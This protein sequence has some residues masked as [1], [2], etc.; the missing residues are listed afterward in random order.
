MCIIKHTTPCGLAID[1]TLVGAYE[2]ALATDPTSA[3]GS[4]ISLNRRVDQATAE[5]LSKLFVECVVAPGYDADAMEILTQKKNIR[6]LTLP[7]RGLGLQPG[8][9]WGWLVGGC[10]SRDPERRPIPGQPQPEA[11]RPRC[12]GAC[13][14]A[15]S[16]RAPRTLPTSAFAGRNGGS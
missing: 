12:S 9:G 2:K 10:R 8:A 4:V 5:A 11:R 6:L 1:E 14:A 16:C 13:T 7:G 3:F 15:S